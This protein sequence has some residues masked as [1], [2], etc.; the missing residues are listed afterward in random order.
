MNALPLPCS[1]YPHGE[2][3]YQP[4]LWNKLDSKLRATHNCYTYMLNDLYTKPRLYGKPQPGHFN[5]NDYAYSF[6]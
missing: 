1:Q 5:N 2:P 6:V 3:P 4:L